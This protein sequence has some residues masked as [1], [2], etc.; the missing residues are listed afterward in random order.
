MQRY[1]SWGSVG[2]WKEG[3]WYP[4]TN[5]PEEVAHSSWHPPYMACRIEACGRDAKPAEDAPDI[6]PV[7][8]AVVV[9]ARNKRLREAGCASGSEAQPAK[10]RC[11]ESDEPDVVAPPAATAETAPAAEEAQPPATDEAPTKQPP[12]KRVS[13]SIKEPPASVPQC[14]QPMNLSQLRNP[15][16][17]TSM[18]P[19]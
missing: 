9:A 10:V 3:K 16:P 18:H 11:I 8:Q 15:P 13:F 2:V 5:I 1:E 17:C 6:W 4:S 14:P 12:E 7:P 19:F